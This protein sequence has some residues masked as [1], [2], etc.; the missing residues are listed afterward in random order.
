MTHLK[1]DN[2]A[3][4]LLTALQQKAG[5]ID[6]AVEAKVREAC[7]ASKKPLT[8]VA[9][10]KL[11]TEAL[12]E[13][14]KVLKEVSKS[15]AGSGHHADGCRADFLTQQIG[16]RIEKDRAI[17]VRSHRQSPPRWTRDPLYAK[18]V[19]DNDARAIA[20]FNGRDVDANGS[21]LLMKVVLRVTDPSD[22]ERTAKEKQAFIDQMGDFG[23]YRTTWKQPDIEV[24]ARD[25]SY[26]ET[27]D[28]QENE[29]EFGDPLVHVSLD[30][31]GEELSRGVTVN[32]ENQM[33]TRYYPADGAGNPRTHLN[34]VRAAQVQVGPALDNT[35][36]AFFEDKIQLKMSAKPEFPE[37][38]WLDDVKSE[39]VQTTLKVEPGFFFEPGK[40]AD[41]QFQGAKVQTQVASDDAF[42]LGSHAATTEVPVQALTLRQLLQQRVQ[43]G[44]SSEDQAQHA[45]GDVVSENK[46]AFNYIF[47]DAANIQVGGGAL[48]PLGD[49][50]LLRNN[51]EAAKVGVTLEPCAKKD[52]PNAAK[53]RI[54]LEEGFL[55][56]AEGASVQ[57]WT[58][59]L[60]FPNGQGEWVQVQTDPVCG[61]HA[62]EPGSFTLEVD[63]LAKV[64]KNNAGLEL[65]AYNDSGVPAMR[66]KVPFV[67]MPW[68]DRVLP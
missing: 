38:G 62:S 65:R 32:P 54:K 31:H 4:F 42:L 24:V 58:V 16:L 27:K 15:C 18:F 68:A 23:G 64:M 22:E 51:F 57:G 8:A 50:Q 11:L 6:G 9:L 13:Q 45:R 30:H 33:T 60:G 20:L 49:R 55:A 26:V 17:G 7:D 48:Q 52:A 56:A 44:I 29:F 41:I 47:A 37:G 61:R 2:A 63:D 67:A 35:R 1:L 3:K 53:L 66:V 40:K 39:H 21:P 25:A 5:V 34:E 10:E 28:L 12:P 43:F 14:S 46:P 59:A 19:M 36:P